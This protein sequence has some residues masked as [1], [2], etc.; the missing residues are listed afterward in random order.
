[1]DLKV[2][3]I[4][5]CLSKKS[6]SSGLIRACLQSQHPHLNIEIA[7]ISEFP[8]INPDIIAEKGFP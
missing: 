8:L 3:A 1:M 5:G 6:A 4:S 2:V 7:D